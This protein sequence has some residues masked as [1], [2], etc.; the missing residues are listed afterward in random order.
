M[1]RGRKKTPTKLKELRG[2]VRNDRLVQNEMQATLVLK[3]PDP[4]NWLSEIGQIE[5]KK[6]C[7]ELY[8]KNMLHEIDLRL[9]EA[10]ANEISLYI[11]TE[12]L[13]RE[14]GRIQ[15]YKNSDGTIKHAQV[16]PYVKVARDALNS[17]MKIATQFGLTPSA[18]SSISAPQINI[19]HNEHNY[20][21]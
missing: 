12:Q 6:V 2:T 4:P 13:L 5:F 16:V 1:T 3:I 14:K 15:V 8:G 20:F 19:Q 7:T 18:R 9:I 21:D 10:Y 11:E 17:A